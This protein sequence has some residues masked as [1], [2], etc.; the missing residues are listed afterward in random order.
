MSD[1]N[2][3]DGQPLNEGFNFNKNKRRD[4]SILK[5]ILYGIK[6]DNILT[7]DEINFLKIWLD[8]VKHKTGDFYDISYEI[9][10]MMSDGKITA[11]EMEELNG[12]IDDCIYYSPINNDTNDISNEFFGFIRGIISDGKI[13]YAEYSKLLIN[14]ER[15]GEVSEQF[16][17]KQIISQLKQFLNLSNP[18]ESELNNLLVLLESI[19]G[20][21]FTK[22]GDPIGSPAFLF[23]DPM[24]NPNPGNSI[25]FTGKFLSGSRN[26]HE[27]IAKKLGLIVKNDTSQNINY[28]VVGSLMSRDWLHHN[29]G[30]KLK[31]AID[32]KANGFAIS[33]VNEIEW[34]E[35]IK[36]KS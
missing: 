16:P 12:L 3:T 22:D 31:K 11:D 8:N 7:S 30:T 20:T 19:T 9:E 25:C 14:L 29:A 17:Y 28:V 2:I 15:F 26:Y 4:A 34:C 27:D 24:G 1:L 35:F 5:G 18:S 36:E 32:F 33:I 13:N 6:A 23:K 21:E 10:K